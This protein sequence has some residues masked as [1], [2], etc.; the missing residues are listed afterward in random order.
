LIKNLELIV[1]LVNL[2]FYILENDPKHKIHNEEEAQA[3]ETTADGKPQGR[4]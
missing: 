3:N 2:I 4:F 1:S